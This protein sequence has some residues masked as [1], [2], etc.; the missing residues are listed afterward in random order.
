MIVRRIFLL[1]SILCSHLIPGQG[2]NLF[3][4]G[5]AL[6]KAFQVEAALE[7]YEAFLSVN[8]NHVEALTRAS[9]IYSNIGGR[10]KEDMLELKK[11]NLEKARA[12]GLKA[13]SLD[14]QDKEARLAY[15][16]SLGLLSEVAG[17]PRDKIRDAKIIYEQAS[18]IL[19]LDS[20]FA[21]AYFIL[22]KWHFELAKLNWMEQLACEI[23]FG[24]MPEG[25]SMDK[26]LQH[27]RK[28]SALEPTS[29]IYLF[30]EASV[31]HHEGDDKGALVLLKRAIT[32]PLKEP[33][34]TLR[35]ERCVKLLKEI[36]G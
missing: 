9:R 2:Q 33:D 29:I 21:A 16:I 11:V 14:P 26:A 24:G 8:P 10:M 28:A 18:A 1:F 3:S 22:G 19:V 35:K 6:E 20:T 17:S 15:V 31:L 30:G 13:V 34:D 5:L 36:E 27:M 12:L 23:F 4:E 7:K 32:L 25:V